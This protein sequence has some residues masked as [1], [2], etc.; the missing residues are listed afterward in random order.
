M[1]NYP[2]GI[3]SKIGLLKDEYLLLQ[4]FYEDYD[5]RIMGIK[6]WSTTIC[7]AALGG[8]FYQSKLLWLFAAGSGIVFW[9][10]DAVWKS[11]QYNYAPRIALLEEAFRSG[12]LES[13]E[14]LQIYTSWF[15]SYRSNRS[16]F[17]GRL[18]MAIVWFPHIIPVIAGPTL[19]FLEQAGVFTIVRH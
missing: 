5:A 14:P 6:G 18:S 10:L 17:R 1:T 11:F 12:N 13:I 19:F 2:G 3:E 15:N 16:K 4:N 9:I 7:L 8:G